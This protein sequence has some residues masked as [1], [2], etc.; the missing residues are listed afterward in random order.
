MT[1]AARLQPES[2]LTWERLAPTVAWGFAGLIVLLFVGGF[3]LQWLSLAARLST[4]AV[5]QVLWSANCLP[6][7]LVGALIAHKQRRNPYGWIWLLLAFA[8]AAQYFCV[9]YATYGLNMTSGKLP[10]IDLA[11]TM[12][13]FAW[14]ITII[15]ISFIFLLFP[16]GRFPSRRWRWLAYLLALIFL[17]VLTF[18]WFLPGSSGFF[19]GVDNPYAVPGLLGE[20]SVLV[21]NLASAIGFTSILLSAVSLVIRFRRAAGVERQQ[22]KWLAFSSVVLVLVIA[23]D[24]VISLP[25]VWEYVKESLSFAIMPVS[26]GV[27]ILR[28][29]LYDIDLIIRRTLLYSLLT[30]VLLLVYFSIVTLLQSLFTAASGQHSTLAIVLS[31]LAIAALFNPLRRRIQKALDTRFYRRR[32]NVERALADFAAAARRETDL[33]GLTNQLTRLTHQTMQPASLSLWLRSG[34]D[35]GGK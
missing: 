32:Y 35:Q 15:L 1:T 14:F 33:T 31:T 30:G 24:F 23:S 28:Y 26:V 8:N 4:E 34:F 7:A 10:G 9:G 13:G 20:V 11:L 22:I 17:A 19:P 25:G 5:Q 16:T 12:P 29:R 2:P 3:A 27:A 18:G 21:V 6:S